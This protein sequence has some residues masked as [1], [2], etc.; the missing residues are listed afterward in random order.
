[1]SA[2]RDSIARLRAWWSGTECSTPHS[3]Y[4]LI[5]ELANSYAARSRAGHAAL[6]VPLPT[7]EPNAI[8]RRA[9]GCE[10]LG[11]VSTRFVL[12]DQEWSAPAAA[13]ICMDPRLV[14]AFA[15]L[16]ADIATRALEAPAWSSILALV[17]E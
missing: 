2:D 7:M 16:A 4:H 10:L 3:D 8:G 11:H 1:M 13:L 12:P 5:G 17:E 6:V 15:V 9:S 14:D